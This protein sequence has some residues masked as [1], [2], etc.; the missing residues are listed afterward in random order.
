MFSHNYFKLFLVLSIFS[1]F[2]SCSIFDSK[3]SDEGNG[4]DDLIDELISIS[5]QI[6]AGELNNIATNGVNLGIPANALSEDA[7][8]AL[9]LY[10][11]AE[12]YELLETAGISFDIGASAFAS[13]LSISFATQSEAGVEINDYLFVSESIESITVDGYTTAEISNAIPGAIPGSIS[14]SYALAIPAAIPGAIPGAIPSYFKASEIAASFEMKA[15]CIINN[16]AYNISI[17]LSDNGENIV[18]IIPSDIFTE[19]VLGFQIALWAVPADEDIIV[20]IEDENGVLSSTDI[21][22]IP[23]IRIV[24]SSNNTNSSN[25][26]ET[27]TNKTHNDNDTESETDA[28]AEDEDTDKSQAVHLTVMGFSPYDGETDVVISSVITINF[29]EQIDS[30]SLDLNVENSNCTGTIQMSYNDFAAETCVPFQSQFVISG[31]SL[32]IYPNSELEFDTTYKIKVRTTIKDINGNTLEAE[33]T[34]TTGFTIR[35]EETGYFARHV[36][37]TAAGNLDDN[38]QPRSLTLADINSDNFL[39]CLVANSGTN[40]I[41]VR[42]GNAQGFSPGD[43]SPGFSWY[44]Q[45]DGSE[46]SDI[47][48]AQMN[49]HQDNKLDIVFSNYDEGSVVII[50]GYYRDDDQNSSNFENNYKKKTSLIDNF[51]TQEHWEVSNLALGYLN[52]PDGFID[53]AVTNES[54]IIYALYEESDGHFEA[55]VTQQIFES[56]A[57]LITDIAIAD[58]NNDGKH[59]I[60]TSTSNPDAIEIRLQGNFST[61]T[62]ISLRNYTQD[63]PTPKAIAKGNVDND[64]GNCI[65]LV[66]ANY[67]TDNISIFINSCEGTFVEA[68]TRYSMGSN[69]IDI[70]LSYINDDDY[71]DVATANFGSHNVSVRFGVGDGT[72][73]E[74]YNFDVGE[75]PIKLYIGDINNDTFDDIVTANYTA[76][77]ISYLAGQ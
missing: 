28:E 37:Y 49:S 23:T 68:E 5:E 7:L 17:Y 13:G 16:V 71:L 1:L 53:V 63:Y 18:Y 24:G 67:E 14:E 48:I 61:P 69:P 9:S 3:E 70:F 19:K 60:A 38:P 47:S 8:V 41:T 65:D 31:N 36:E 6:S 62:I 52:V 33:H 66:T 40:E 77:T 73:G 22:E 44:S 74:L 46:P 27:S 57:S 75:G 20:T 11:E 21:T 51:E 35:A 4:V 12:F 43:S 58:F 2:L 39:D 29:S 55:P 45:N 32:T 30:S 25:D 42:L 15:I 54:K 56:T 34:S 26:T 76:G 72:F 10:T 50:E 64:E 59:D